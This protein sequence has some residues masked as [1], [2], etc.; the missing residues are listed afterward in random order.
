MY[1]HVIIHYDEIGLKKKNRA[2]FE[3][4]L[5]KNIQFKLKN[6]ISSIYKI[7]GRLVCEI[8]KDTNKEQIINK[9]L[10]M[11]GVAFFSF[12]VKTTLDIEDISKKTLSLLSKDVKSF[13]IDTKRGNKQYELTSIDVN[14]IVGQKIVNALKLKVDLTSPSVTAYIELCDKE[15]F[16][17]TQK[18]NGIS[19]LPIREKNKVV[20][21]LSGGL[22]SPVS[23]YMMMKRGCQVVFVHVQNNTQTNKDLEKKIKDLVKILTNIQLKSTLLII[24]FSE[25]QKQIIAYVPADYRMIIYRRFMMKLIEKI[26]DTENAFAI[27]TGDS[28]GQV[29]SQTLENIQAIYN[30]TTKPVFSPLI[31]LNKEEIITVAK[32]INTYE[33]SIKP[34]PDCCSFMIAVHPKTKACL[35]E[36]TT[37]EENIPN[38][39]KLIEDAL[40]NTKKYDFVYEKESKL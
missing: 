9:L 37:I 21:S 24:P 30:A 32:K 26:V 12:A 40:L 36:V 8:T 22:D 35:T 20:C 15:S 1:T 2:Y 23:A 39:Q 10:L 28:V 11:P 33:T 25:I 38:K 5:K 4:A 34:Y 27:V 31:G 13:K 7:R 6:N 14:K 29:A 3:D 17:Y 16:I 18:T 19:G